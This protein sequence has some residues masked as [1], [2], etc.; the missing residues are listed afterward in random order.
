MESVS[1]NQSPEKTHVW[2]YL[3][4][5]L[6]IPFV[7]R[8]SQEYELLNGSYF[9]AFE[10]EV[11]PRCIATPKD[12]DEVRALVTALRPHILAKQCRIAIRGTG[13]TPFSGSANIENGITIDMRKLKGIAISEDQ[14]FVEIGA[15][16]TWSAVYSKLEPLQLT[17]SGARVGRIGVAGFLLGGGLSLFSTNNGFACDSVVEFEVVLASGAVACASDR[18]N[19]ELFWA[20]KGGLNNYGIVTSFKMKTYKWHG[21]IWG[22][23]VYYTP[24]C[25]TQLLKKTVDF[26]KDETDRDTHVMFSAGYGFSQEVLSCVLYHTRGHENAPSLQPFLSVQPQLASTM[27]KST[28]AELSEELSK[29]STDGLRQYWGSITIHADVALMGEFYQKW[30][31]TLENIKDAEGFVFSFGFHLL[32]KS[33]LENS[34]KAGGNPAAIPPSDGPLFVV[35]INPSWKLAE[36]DERVFKTVKTFTSELKR[37][38]Q[39]RDLLHRYIFTN[40]ALGEDDVIGGYGNESVTKLIATAQRYDPD[41]VFQLGVPGG[42]KLPSDVIALVEADSKAEATS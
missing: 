15:G 5:M 22:G 1:N 16:E 21:S 37:L 14:S 31:A 18:E 41:G 32:S 13:H 6:S 19:P 27:R 9:S 30:Q 28:Q 26:A 36:D 7:E 25:F 40:Y 17:V 42:F 11:K 35:L 23:L 3:A 10:N 38:A 39:E 24:E 34:Q 29:F 12:V 33:L 2:D 20:L 8:G 4:N